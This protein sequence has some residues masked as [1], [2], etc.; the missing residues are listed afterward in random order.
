MCPRPYQLGRRQA[1]TEQTRARILAAARELLTADD[2]LSGFSIDAVARRADVARMTVYYQFGSRVGL[3]EAI[4]DDLAAHG[5]MEDMPSVFQRPDP[6]DALAVY[7]AAFGRFY[8]SDRLILRRLRGLATLDHDLE[9]ALYARGERRRTGLR[10]IVQHIS[11]RYGWPTPETT[12]E[13]INILHMLT[14]FE[15]FDSLAGATRGPQDIAPLVQ[16]LTQAALNQD[17]ASSTPAL[18]DRPSGDAPS[19]ACPLDQDKST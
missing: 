9:Q 1:A 14:S 4:F 18:A 16:R 2:S 17:A 6:L 13:A 8:D 15:T 12:D 5:G 19:A 7:I 10:V 11:E 3:L